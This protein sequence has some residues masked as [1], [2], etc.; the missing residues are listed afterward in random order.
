MTVRARFEVMGLVQG[1][2]FRPFVHRLATE[3]GL[4]G[5]V[6]NDATQVF[7]ECSGPADSVAEFETRLR[8]DAP[9]LA[10]VTEVRRVRSTGPRPS[11]RGFSIAE[12]GPG[13]RDAGRTFVAPD[14]AVCEDCRRE[15]HDP[16]DRRFGHPFITCTNCG[17]RFTI[18][19]SLPYD[20]SATTMVG[21]EMCV[22]CREEYENPADRRFHAQPIGCHGCGP[23]LDWLDTHGRP[24]PG[25]PIDAA[26]E[27]LASGDIVAIKGLG[28]FHLAVDATDS[29]AVAELR[30]RKHR[31]DKPFAVMVADLGEAGRLAEISE[32]EA[33]LLRSPARPIVLC[34]ALATSPLS[35]LVAP[36]NP[37]IG[38]MLPY[39]PVHLL[40]FET[41]PGLGPIVMTSGNA[42]GEPIC[43]R[44]DHVVTRVGPM[45]DAILTH[46][47][48]IHVPCD[49]SVVRMTGR[50]LLPIRRS[51]G[52][53]PMP[54]ALPPGPP[55]SSPSG[56]S[57]L[58]VGGEL[59]NAF[60]VTNGSH[61]WMSQHIG[62]MENLETLEAFT[63]SI[64][65]FCD[66]Y[67]L[68]PDIVVA[69]THPA[70]RSSAWA[71]SNHGDRIVEVQHHHAHVAAVMAEHG[72]DPEV[73]VLGIAFDG[74]G[75]GSDGTIWGGEQLVATATTAERIAHLR[76][77]PLPGGDAAVRHPW[78]VALSHLR[79]AGVEW[80]D[81]LPPVAAA[82][83]HERQLLAQQLERD[84]GCVPT[85]SMGR[86]FDA[87]ASLVGLRHTISYEAQAAIDLEIAAAAWSGPTPSFTFTLADP[88]PLFVGVVSALR[89]H[90]PVGA[91]ARACHRAIAEGVGNEVVSE[92][93]RRGID[94]VVLSGGV[95]QNVLFTDMLV[96]QLTSADVEVHTHRLVPPNDGGLALGQA[97]IA[98][99]RALSLTPSAASHQTGA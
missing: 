79:S 76:H 92:C 60:C 80:T 16:A 3:L 41:G 51:R 21:F 2:G 50:G 40:L 18:T 77:T 12:S 95:F 6:G 36:G 69:D 65:Q 81:D 46:D 53:A 58:A 23:R 48:P 42:G 17:P 87:L 22:E 68:R 90:V 39:T 7:I 74:T 56:R 55:A 91:I 11:G 84:L 49:D 59:K 71:R 28:G 97:L 61:A 99:Q 75:D 67:D 29:D 54:L 83:V 20:R 64:D 4:D 44:D 73:A 27:R 52:Y 57:I 37:L 63:T 89:T 24:L 19:R 88:G 38:I 10:V 96:D 72:L 82:A 1:V 30:T 86:L 13:D 62:D 45:V 47:R 66:L 14:T 31:P 78:R 15:M 32:A 98:H 5:M 35:S 25:D 93:R 26:R 43:H 94:T 9:P 34:R 85:S 33:E 8:S 70:Y